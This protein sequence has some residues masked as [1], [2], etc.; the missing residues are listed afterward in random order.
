MGTVY[1]TIEQGVREF[2][3]RQHVFF[4]ASAP[5]AADG[6]VNLS[7]KGYDTLR[8]VD[9]RRIAYLDLTGSGVETIAHARENGRI[10]LMFCAFEGPP[11]IVR[12]HGRASVQA[13]DHPDLAPLFAR[14]RSARA[15]VEIA[16]DRVSDSCGYSVPLLRYE[17]ER[18][19]LTKWVD[20]R[21]DEQIV[22]Y[23]AANNARSLDGLPGV[24]IL[25]G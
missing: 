19:R 1:D 14:A 8:V 4:V 11:R 13:P 25:K 16:V 7:P 5:L 18:D 12:I 20:A 23:Q 6:H 3:G 21:T 10:T 17:G 22:E 9:E 2:I 24:P 15:I